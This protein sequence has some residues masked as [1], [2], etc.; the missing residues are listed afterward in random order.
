MLGFYVTAVFNR[1]HDVFDNL[2]WIDSPALL[3]ATYVRG[4]SEEARNV[5]RNIIRYMVLVQALVFRDIST[6]VQ[7]RFPTMDHLVTSGGESYL[8]VLTA[9][10]KFHRPDDAE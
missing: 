8:L 7:K 5:R 4:T 9:T 3:I 10:E 2:G 1:W 6:A